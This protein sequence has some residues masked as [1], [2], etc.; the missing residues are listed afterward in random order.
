MNKNSKLYAT[1]MASIMLGMPTL[2]VDD[3][4]PLGII[5]KPEIC[6]CKHCKQKF[7]PESH[8]KKVFCSA[9]CFKAYQRSKP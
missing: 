8:N 9:E 2:G 7:L 3:K 5:D 6:V 4:H 1:M